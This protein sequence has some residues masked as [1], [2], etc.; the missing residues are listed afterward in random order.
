MLVGFV[1]TKPAPDGKFTFKG[2][3][4]ASY[5]LFP[6][7]P[8]GL[9]VA[10]FRMG[11]RS[12]YEDGT[13]RLSESNEP[14][15]IVLSSSTAAVSGTVIWPNGQKGAK[16]VAVLVPDA[17][18]RHNHYVY[19]QANTD[20]SDQFRIIGVPPGNYKLFA[21]DATLANGWRNVDVI[22][23]YEDIG[24]PVTVTASSNITGLQVT[25][26]DLGKW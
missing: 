21:C 4:G 19:K 13:F 23:K 1:Q 16:T 26:I 25:A 20:E 24:I 10:D 12:H 11:D 3:L 9:Y 22:S 5:S 6:T 2:A 17:P 14:I 7:M 8:S 18:L 15:Q